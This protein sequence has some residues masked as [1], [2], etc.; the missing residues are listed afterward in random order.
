[1]IHKVSHAH[2]DTV[3]DCSYFFVLLLFSVHIPLTSVGLMPYYGN[4]VVVHTE[5]VLH[6][7]ESKKAKRRR[8]V[9]V[10]QY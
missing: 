1:M 9:V 10:I 8:V 2:Y 3:C 5:L 4:L 7:L 6:I